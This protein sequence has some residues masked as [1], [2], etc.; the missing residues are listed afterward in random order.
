MGKQM[1]AAI[2][3]A[4]CHSIPG[5]QSTR[6]AKP[7]A[8]INPEAGEGCLAEHVPKGLP[9]YDLSPEQRQALTAAIKAD[10]DPAVIA[11]PLE[12][13]SRS[14]MSWPL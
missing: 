6:T 14:F 3:C 11:T 9:D 10:K 13:G 8:Q 12:R 4:S 7:L 1:F 2:G 5:E